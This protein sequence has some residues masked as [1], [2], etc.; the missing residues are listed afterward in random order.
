MNV[1]LAVAV[2]RKEPC[3][4]QYCGSKALYLV[5]LSGIEP[6]AY[7]L[8][9]GNK[10]LINTAIHGRQPRRKHTLFPVTRSPYLA[11]LGV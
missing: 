1:P 8:G 6:L 7:P 4:Q 11:Q 3:Y 2:I 10:I 5:P 9:V